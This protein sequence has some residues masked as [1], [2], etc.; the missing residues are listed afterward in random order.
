MELNIDVHSQYSQKVAFKFL[1]EIFHNW[2][3]DPSP[4]QNV[5]ELLPL[6]IKENS[7]QLKLKKKLIR[8]SKREYSLHLSPLRV[9]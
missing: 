2:Y 4:P 7:G 9:R 3:L 6:H 1:K 8:R 5:K